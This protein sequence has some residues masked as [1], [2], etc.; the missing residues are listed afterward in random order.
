MCPVVRTSMIP[1]KTGI[2]I[3]P[4]YHVFQKEDL[5]EFDVFANDGLVFSEFFLQVKDL[6]TNKTCGYWKIPDLGPECLK[7]RRE[8][9][10]TQFRGRFI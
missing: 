10:N 7:L 4:I 6:K 2:K 1:S 8:I 9:M 3:A 5:V